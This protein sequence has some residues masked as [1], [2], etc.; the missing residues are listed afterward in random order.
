MTQIR[1]RTRRLAA[2][3]MTASALLVTAAVSPAHAARDRVDDKVG[4]SRAYNDVTRVTIKNGAKR[5][6]V[7]AK[8]RNLGRKNFSSGVTID[9][10]DK[11]KWV[12]RFAR[13]ED[14]DGEMVERLIHYNR[15]RPASGHRVACHRADVGYFPGPESKMVFTL[16]QRCLKIA[17]DAWF[18]VSGGMSEGEEP[19][20]EEAPKRP[21]FVARG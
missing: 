3:G 20:Y 6:H 21:V 7:V 19:G 16:P 4:D 15:K 1:L 2:A 14:W 8:Y 12:Y 18:Q 11:G 9:T 13:Y 17:G 10:G 5:I